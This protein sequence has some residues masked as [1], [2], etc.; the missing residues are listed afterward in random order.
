M[1]L[2]LVLIKT[3]CA[4]CSHGNLMYYKYNSKKSISKLH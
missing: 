3:E 2:L 1:D 4:R